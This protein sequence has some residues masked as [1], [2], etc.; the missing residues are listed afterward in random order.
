MTEKIKLC[1]LEIRELDD[2]DNYD[3]LDFTDEDGSDPLGVHEFFHSNKAREFRNQKLSTI[4]V[5]IYKEKVIACFTL[6]MSA[7]NTSKLEKDE[8]VEKAG[9]ITTYPGVLLGQLGVDKEFRH[10]DVG[11]WIGQHI[12]GLARDFNKKIACRYIVLQTDQNKIKLYEKLQFT[13]SI[14]KPNKS[15]GTVW[16]YRNIMD[17][18]K[19]IQ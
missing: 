17:I 12:S 2:S 9:E 14:K 19:D 18:Q 10:R 15:N 11:Y 4:W 3:K 5:V 1:E 8:I 13:K 16:M 6:S 7:I